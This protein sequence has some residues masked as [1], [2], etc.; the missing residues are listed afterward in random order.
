MPAPP[1]ARCDDS[2]AVPV[3]RIVPLMRGGPEEHAATTALIFT[4]RC[5]LSATWTSRA[6]IDPWHFLAIVPAAQIRFFRVSGG[7]VGIF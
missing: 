2:K 6:D 1:Q 7:S 5:Y 4:S 3:T